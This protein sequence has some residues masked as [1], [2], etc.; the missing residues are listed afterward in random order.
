MGDAASQPGVADS[1]ESVTAAQRQRAIADILGQ[2]VLRVINLGL[3]VFV[4]LVL[5][6]ALGA[7]GFGQWSTIFAV[8]QLT[9]Y[10][11]TFGFEQVSVRHAAAEPDHASEWVAALLAL[12][13]ALALPVGLLTAGILVAV[14]GHGPM[15]AAGLITCAIF[16]SGALSASRVVFQLRI[17]ND[18]NA[19][20]ELSNG[21]IWAAA[22]GGLALVHGGL[23][24]FAIAFVVTTWI[25]VLIQAAVAL[26][27]LRPRLSG[28]RSHAGEL[29]RAGVP[30]GISSLL[31][32]AYAR[33]DQVIVFE[34]AGAKA[35]GLYG[36]DYRIL[37]RLQAVPETFMVTLFPLISGLY[38]A[39]LGQVRV[40][41]SRALE[42]LAM[43]S[44]PILAFTLVVPRRSVVLLF[45]H[46]FA[47]AAP[48]L[49]ILMG[50]F[51]LIAFGHVTGY[52]IIV[53]RLQVRFIRYAVAALVF[54]V[55][56]NVILVP[57][58]GF[59]V[60]AGITVATELLV[61]GLSAR[62]VFSQLGFRPPLDRPLRIGLSVAGM[63][64]VTAACDE[65][66]APLGA[67]VAAAICSYL[68]L[69]L[70]S[71]ATSMAEL[72]LILTRRA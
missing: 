26:R 48:G 18:L 1:G 34:L 8:T 64:A 25:P 37:D 11:A 71:R 60:A 16:I 13:M 49:P 70:L 61:L 40:L 19:A 23:V 17:R 65:A 57:S 20:F 36:A 15:L 66:G 53:L 55:V 50:A 27:L 45:G 2:L 41:V 3:G 56:A 68:P 9:G 59:V 44:L 28:A 7:R 10:L 32:I 29:I 69:L 38:P 42:V 62:V 30:V 47:A 4:T 21:I 24:P 58:Y 22:V 14:A 51:I 72:R 6:R 35:A 54:N 12:R 39:D 5:A 43:I 31:I 52:L 33:I 46:A 67:L 63:A